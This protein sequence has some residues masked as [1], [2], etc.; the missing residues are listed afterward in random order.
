M[1]RAQLILLTVLMVAASFIG[2][3][4]VC[5]ILTPPILPLSAY[6]E[7]REFLLTDKDDIN[8]IGMHVIEDGSPC[9]AMWDRNATP[10]LMLQPFNFMMLDSVANPRIQ[11]Y[12]GKQEGFICLGHPSTL[13][14]ICLSITKDGDPELYIKGK[15]GT[16][17]WEAP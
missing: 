11:L 3:A 10:R 6:M 4:V 8:R 7:T 2:G 5:R 16:V 12:Q 17:I 15:D 9:L 14:C 1:S 13:A